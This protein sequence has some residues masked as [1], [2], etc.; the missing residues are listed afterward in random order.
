MFGSKD[1]DKA[2]SSKIKVAGEQ[3]SYNPGIVSI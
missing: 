2:G 1:K 3:S